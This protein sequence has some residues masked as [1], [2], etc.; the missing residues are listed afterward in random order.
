[1]RS[2]RLCSHCVV[3]QSA[4]GETVGHCVCVI[5][6]VRG[7][8]CEVVDSEGKVR[9]FSARYWIISVAES[10]RRGN[11]GTISSSDALASLRDKDASHLIFKRHVACTLA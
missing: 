10:A 2:S 11:R 5:F 9:V 1:M 6:K 3:V 4:L 7:Q 8:S